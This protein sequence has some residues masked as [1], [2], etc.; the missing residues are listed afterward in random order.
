MV[1]S[2]W[3]TLRSVFNRFAIVEP[4]TTAKIDDQRVEIHKGKKV[5]RHSS[6]G[7]EARH[8]PPPH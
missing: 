2:N 6:L 5:M 3:D 4:N 1:K 8:L 7:L